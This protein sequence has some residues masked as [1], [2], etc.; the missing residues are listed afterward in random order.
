MSKPPGQCWYCARATAIPHT[1]GLTIPLTPVVD[2]KGYPPLWQWAYQP[3]P[4]AK[5]KRLSGWARREL[6]PSKRR[7][8]GRPSGRRSPLVEE[9][10]L[11]LLRALAWHVKGIPRDSLRALEAADA[12]SRVKA[13]EWID[14]KGNWLNWTVEQIAQIP[15]I[16]FFWRNRSTLTRDVRAIKSW[17][18]TGQF[19]D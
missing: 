6:P 12:E 11:W 14:K 8:R 4:P 7:R 9:R 18:R 3:A 5:Q 16:A 10:R 15:L 1:V 17:V 19:F 13:A 2:I